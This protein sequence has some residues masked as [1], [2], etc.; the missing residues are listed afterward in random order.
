MLQCYNLQLC[1]IGCQQIILMVLSPTDTD[2]SQLTSNVQ[3]GHRSI[4][5]LSQSVTFECQLTNTSELYWTV[6]GFVTSPDALRFL[7]SNSTWSTVSQGQFTATL[8]V[9]DTSTSD[10]G[11][12][13]LTSTLTFAA[14]ISLDGSL[15]QCHDDM[16]SVASILQIAG[17]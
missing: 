16:S 13:S 17:I 2:R 11:H 4:A 14:R 12:A 7:P 10:P 15:I 8:T 5:C 9:V 6:E 1:E 3:H